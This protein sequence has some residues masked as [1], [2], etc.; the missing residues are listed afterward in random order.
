MYNCM[1]TLS[2]HGGSFLNNYAVNKG[3]CLN[4]C[5]ERG[6]ITN[7]TGGIFAGNYCDYKDAVSDYS[8]SGGI[9]NS[10]VKDGQAELRSRGMPSSVATARKRLEWTEYIWIRT[11]VR[12]EKYLSVLH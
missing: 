12:P 3:G 7:I 5:W 4:H 2:I 9:F 6:T 1:G 11:A 10:S 8:G